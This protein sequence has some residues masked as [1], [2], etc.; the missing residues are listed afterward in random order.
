[1][2]T[3]LSSSEQG[4]ETYGIPS[5]PGEL[6]L[7][8]L[9]PGPIERVWAYLV[10]PEKRRMWFARG[11]M[12]LRAN[13]NM[14]LHFQHK[15]FTRPEEKVPEHYQQTL[16]MAPSPARVTRC[17]PP[18]LLAFE[19]DFCEEPSEVTFELTPE[20]SRVRLVLTHRR[21]LD[22]SE[23]VCVASGW[24]AHVGLLTDLLEG[25]ERRPFWAEHGRL[26]EEYG[27]RLPTF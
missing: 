23:M 14:T 11:E 24:H 27:Q 2:N 8:R 26:E 19:W 20:G 12:E 6:R 21:L 10:E 3:S 7:E 5:A 15:E 18:R 16:D 1:M 22:K 9:L 13:G 4:H 17:E 25:R